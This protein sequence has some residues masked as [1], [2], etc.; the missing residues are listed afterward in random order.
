MF[1]CVHTC[2][3]MCV[4]ASAAPRSS[5]PSRRQT[6]PRPPAP[7]PAGPAPAQPPLLRAPSGFG[8]ILSLRGCATTSR[9]PGFS[10]VLIPPPFLSHALPW[11]HLR[12]HSQSRRWP[13]PRCGLRV[14][15]RCPA[16][17]IS[18]P[19]LIRCTPSPFS[20]G[21]PG[22][23]LPALCLSPLTPLLGSSELPCP[24]HPTHYWRSAGTQ[25]PETSAPTARPH[26]DGAN[27]CFGRWPPLRC[28]SGP[29]CPA[30][31]PSP[32]CAP[33]SCHSPSLRRKARPASS[34][35][36][37]APTSSSVPVT[38][39]YMAALSHKAA[40]HTRRPQSLFP[41]C[42]LTPGSPKPATR[43]VVGLAVTWTCLV[44][45]DAQCSIQPPAAF[46][47]LFPHLA[48]SSPAFPMLPGRAR[49]LGAT[50]LHTLGVEGPTA[51]VLDHFSP[52]RAYS[53]DSTAPCTP[54]ITNFHL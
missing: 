48:L 37:S 16:I 14:S 43:A 23:G 13:Y 44:R 49:L 12:P 38:A 4:H 26:P 2:T 1:V 45:E 47:N 27:G 17:T 30:L 29:L 34:P 46:N 20:L 35:L 31:Q 10:D 53:S 5:R 52:L 22:A 7:V 11:A 41:C 15:A 3:H 33:S 54:T 8:H 21:Q 40:H 24:L 50:A 32:L 42:P 25:A 19:T 28:V 39:T 9:G 36:E 6:K 51:Q 18:F